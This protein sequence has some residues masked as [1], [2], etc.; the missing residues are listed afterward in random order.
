MTEPSRPAAGLRDA[1]DPA[2]QAAAYE[3]QDADE[4]CI[5]DVSATIEG[6]ANQNP[7]IRDVRRN[8]SIP[9]TAGGG[10][11]VPVDEYLPILQEICKKYGVYLVIDE[12]VA[13]FG[14]TG[15]LFA[16][17]HTGVTPDL[18][19]AARSTGAGLLI[20]RGDLAAGAEPQVHAVAL[21]AVDLPVIQVFEDLGLDQEGPAVAAP[22]G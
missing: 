8:V 16:I 21:V 11:I 18:L 7:T 14:R 12:V 1:G 22:A 5:L 9:I 4:I 15:R 13:G 20:A 17:E 2:E 3:G 6:R 19:C 10:I